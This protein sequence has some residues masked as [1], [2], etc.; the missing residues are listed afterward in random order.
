[1]RLLNIGYGNVVSA[2]RVMAVV[3]AESAPARRTVQDARQDKRLI[4][5]T[6]G[7]KAG[8]VVILDNGMVA[9]SALQAETVAARLEAESEGENSHD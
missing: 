2:A 1:M 3:D 6:A 7:H 5:G 4:D 9:L 8:A